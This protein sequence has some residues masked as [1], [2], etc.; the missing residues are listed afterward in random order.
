MSASERLT[1]LS[2]I[3]T[4]TLKFSLYYRLN[5]MGFMT[6]EDFDSE[7]N[8]GNYGFTDQVTALR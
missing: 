2:N 5:L 3:I 8:Y 1:L 6:H 7:G 4:I